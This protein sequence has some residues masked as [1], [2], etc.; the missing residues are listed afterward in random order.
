MTHLRGRKPPIQRDNA[1][2]SKAPS[3]PKRLS[4]YGKAEWKR[5]LPVLIERGTITAGDLAG[6]ENYC[7][8][9]GAANQIADQ[10]SAL[11][12]PDL[13]LGGLQIRYMQ[14]VRQLAAEFGLTPASRGRAG[15]SNAPEEAPPTPSASNMLTIGRTR[16]IA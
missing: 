8:A 4:D 16:P 5:V 1:A 3:A 9:V 13:K 12:V 15:G 10:M 6:I 2:L 11:P 14:T 7:A